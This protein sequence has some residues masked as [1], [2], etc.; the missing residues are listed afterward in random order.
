[1]KAISQSNATCSRSL[2]VRI[3]NDTIHMFDEILA[4]RVSTIPSNLF[5]RSVRARE[6]MVVAHRN[7][8]LPTDARQSHTRR[9]AR[10]VCKHHPD[11]VDCRVSIDSF[12]AWRPRRALFSFKR[13][14]PPR[15]RSELWTAA[16]RRA[17]TGSTSPNGRRPRSRH[18]YRGRFTGARSRFR[19]CASVTTTRQSP[20]HGECRAA[21]APVTAFAD[22]R[23]C[24]RLRARG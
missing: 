12:G 10:P 7:R 4:F 2:R 16:R 22:G 5:S 23:R 9:A 24:T 21:A 18:P 15:R 14:S 19:L 1:M 3:Q 6:T 8:P 11:C 20:T 13:W 17:R